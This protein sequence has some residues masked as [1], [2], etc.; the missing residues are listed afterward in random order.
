[1]AEDTRRAALSGLCSERS[2]RGCACQFKANVAKGYA[3]PVSSNEI[4]VEKQAASIEEVMHAGHFSHSGC[5][6]R[7]YRG[8]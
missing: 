3:C 5:V 6:V 4:S 1:M 2:L 8:T 7:V